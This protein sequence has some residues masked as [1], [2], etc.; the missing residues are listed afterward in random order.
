MKDLAP[1]EEAVET[2]LTQATHLADLLSNSFDTPSGIPRNTLFITGNGTEPS[3]DETNGIATIGTLILEWTRLS[4]ITG[5]S[6]YTELVQKAE[7]YLLAPLNPEL[8]EPF[9]GLIGTELN[10]TTGLFVDSSGGWNGGTDSYYEYLIKM[11]VY[12][13]EKYGFYL[14][15]W[16]AA[17]DSSI[18]YLSSHPT[19]RPDITFLAAYDGPDQL[20]FV[21]T[22]CKLR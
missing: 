19:S 17:I 12:N 22:H 13:S 2:I 1:S 10:V 8:G 6:K 11:Y 20:N 7:D 18:K 4:D 3:D 14:E 9:P 21:S 15:R 16:I 5:D